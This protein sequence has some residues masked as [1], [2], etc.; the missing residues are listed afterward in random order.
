MEIAF[1]IMSGRVLNTLADKPEQLCCTPTE[2]S[3]N[4][5]TKFYRNR[6]EALFWKRIYFL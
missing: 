6:F 1:Q 4:L 3:W 5:T 2:M